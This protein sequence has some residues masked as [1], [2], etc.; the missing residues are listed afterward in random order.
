MIIYAMNEERGNVKVA[1]RGNAKRHRDFVVE[2][3]EF[4]DFYTIP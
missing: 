4:Q 3:D 2:T 1:E